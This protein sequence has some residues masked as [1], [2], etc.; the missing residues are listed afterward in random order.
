MH[1][2]P[3]DCRAVHATLSVDPGVAMLFGASIGSNQP[4]SPGFEHGAV[5]QQKRHIGLAQASACCFMGLDAPLLYQKAS[6]KASRTRPRV[7]TPAQHLG[8][9]AHL[10]QQLSHPEAQR[11]P[12]ELLT[13]V[14]TARGAVI[15]PNRQK[16]S[17]GV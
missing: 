6:A 16:N 17:S 14:G 10:D 2:G 13:S 8:V 11:L 9:L 1:S 4:A 3:Q 7:S 5:Q 15:K 12:A